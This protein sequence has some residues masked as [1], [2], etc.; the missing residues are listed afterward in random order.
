MYDIRTSVSWVNH[1]TKRG[2][3]IQEEQ[4]I[5]QQ[6][7]IIVYLFVFVFCRPSLKERPGATVMR[8]LDPSGKLCRSNLTRRASHLSDTVGGWAHTAVNTIRKSN[9]STRD[10][11]RAFF[12]PSCFTRVIVASLLH[13]V[14]TLIVE[15]FV[16]FYVYFLY[17][18]L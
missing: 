18:F 15:L 8:K 12:L 10:E 16:L 6:E 14:L 4:K 3:N 5:N 2:G 7:L 1:G 9:W 11:H 17:I 13:V